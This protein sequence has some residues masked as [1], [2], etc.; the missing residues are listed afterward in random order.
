MGRGPLAPPEGDKD[1]FFEWFLDK[2]VQMRMFAA[3][4]M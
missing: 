3:L 4:K 2:R 1:R